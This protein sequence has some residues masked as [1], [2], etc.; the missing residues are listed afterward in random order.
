LDFGLL[1]RERYTGGKRYLDEKWRR[2]VSALISENP[3]S[4]I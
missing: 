2:Q 4:K 1:L 3:K